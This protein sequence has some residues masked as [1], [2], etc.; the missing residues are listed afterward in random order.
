[1]HPFR[2]GLEMPVLL[3]SYATRASGGGLEAALHLHASQTRGSA[4]IVMPR[5]VRRRRLARTATTEEVY[6]YASH[7]PLVSFCKH[8]VPIGIRG[9]IVCLS[10]W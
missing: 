4:I 1:V 3:G 5:Q 8:L 9:R 7:R 10:P 2:R 6:G